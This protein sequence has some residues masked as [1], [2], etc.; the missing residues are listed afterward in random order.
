MHMQP[1]QEH[2]DLLRALQHSIATVPNM[3]AIEILAIA[4][5]FV[6]QLVALQDAKTMTTDRAMQIVLGNIEIGNQEAVN[7]CVA[8]HA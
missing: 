4:S 1:N 5:Q 3:P 8:G 7:N 6:G 2:Y